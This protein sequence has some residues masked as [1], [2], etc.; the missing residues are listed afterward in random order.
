MP[1][2]KTDEGLAYSHE[3]KAEALKQRF[4]VPN[5]P[6]VP[7][8]L[9]DDPPHHPAR[10]M[11]A[12]ISE[13]VGKL[14]AKMSNISAPGASGYTWQCLKWLWNCDRQ[15]IMTL[16]E[17]CISVGHHPAEGKNAII[18]I[19]PKPGQA[20]YS[21]PK[22]FRPISL[23]DCLGKLIEKVVAH[24]FYQ[25]IIT[26]DLLPTNQFGGWVASSTL[27]AGLCLMH[28]AQTAHAAGLCSGVLLF[29]ICGF[30]DNVN[31]ARLAQVVEDLG[32]AP[33]LVAWTRSFISERTVQL[34]FNSLLS[35]PFESNVGTPQ[36]SPV[37]P[38][39]SV[40]YT[41]SL[42]HKVRN[43]QHLSLSMYVN[44]GL[45][46][47]CGNTWEEVTENLTR[48][49]IE[50]AAWL[51]SSGLVIEPDKTKLLFFRQ[52]QDQL[53]PPGGILLPSPSNA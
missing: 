3:G 36:G 52:Q 1:P 51:E 26:H 33:S 45:L 27:D 2:L 12:L 39:L 31:R 4:F 10:P 23:L 14:L 50:C 49:Y 44:D 8:K 35:D 48:G 34:C 37:S 30:F 42:L 46:F 9:P 19:I 18:C 29:D 47:A 43:W 20:D 22:I 32:F 17:A 41:S 21:L 38:V 13:A 25:E 5:P 16:I 40:L 28:D 6:P 24:L 7:Q 53:E 15:C 11:P